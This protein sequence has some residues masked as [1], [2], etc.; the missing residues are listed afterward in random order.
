MN[1]NRDEK[2]TTADVA[3]GHDGQE[4]QAENRETH[5]GQTD[6]HE[7]DTH[8]VDNRQTENR[9]DSVASNQPSLLGEGSGDRYSEHWQSIQAKFVDEPQDSVKE[10]DSLVAEV[11]QELARKFAEQRQQLEGRWS[12]GSE[13][14][15]EDLRQALQQYRSFFQRLLAA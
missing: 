13:V 8:Q 12:T 1:E 6:G 2:I 10:A 5:T 4:H 15:T 7:A 3:Y 14:S 9:H 11:I